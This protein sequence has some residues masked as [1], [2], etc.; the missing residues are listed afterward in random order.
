MKAVGKKHNVSSMKGTLTVLLL[1]DV[2]GHAVANIP[3]KAATA[4]HSFET[5]WTGDTA[6]V[7]SDNK[8]AAT[9]YFF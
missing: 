9:T 7:A 3:E 6:C 4:A 5:T 8:L 1:L 2:S